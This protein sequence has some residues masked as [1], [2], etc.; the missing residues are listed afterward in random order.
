VG[1]I[2]GEGGEGTFLRVLRGP[3]TANA[4][5]VRGIGFQIEKDDFGFRRLGL[6]DDVTLP[7][8]DGVD[9]DTVNWFP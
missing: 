5:I 6:L 3:H 2:L 8:L 9:L 4:N 7:P 1:L